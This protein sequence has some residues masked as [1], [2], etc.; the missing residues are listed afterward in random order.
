MNVNSSNNQHFSRRHFIGLFIVTIIAFSLFVPALFIQQTPTEEVPAIPAPVGD[1]F[2]TPEI[3]ATVAGEPNYTRESW[4]FILNNYPNFQ[5]QNPGQF[6]S[7]WTSNGGTNLG[8]IT[9]SP[10]GTNRGFDPSEPRAGVGTPAY[11]EVFDALEGLNESNIRIMY[12]NAD[13]EWVS[14]PYQIDPKGW[15]NVWQ[16]ADLNRW[17]GLDANNVY[18]NGG[19]PHIAADG[20]VG[21]GYIAGDMVTSQGKATY[22]GDDLRWDWYRIPVWTYL[23]PRQPDGSITDETLHIDPEYRDDLIW[24]YTYNTTY[25]PHIAW[26]EGDM[27]PTGA[28]GS[29]NPWNAQPLPSHSATRTNTPRYAM[30]SVHGW[31]PAFVNCTT[32]TD[33]RVDSTGYTNVVFMG[34]TWFRT[35]GDYAFNP[36]WVRNAF[37]YQQINGALDKDDEIV[38]YASPGRKAA[39]WYWWNYTYFPH[40]FEL[41]I[42][43]PIDGGRTW[44]YIYFNNESWADPF[45]GGINL[46]APVFTAPD[47]NGNPTSDYI[48]W[49]P[50]TRTLSSD[51]YQVSLNATNPSLID[52][53]SIF[54]DTDGQPIAKSFN[55]MYLYGRI[56]ETMQN[57]W[58]ALWSFGK[59]GVWYSYTNGAGSAFSEMI[60]S[61][62]N[63]SV[64][65]PGIS[66]D[67]GVTRTYTDHGMTGGQVTGDRRAYATQPACPQN[68]RGPQGMV[69]YPSDHPYTQ[70]ERSYGDGRA[71]IDGPVRIIFYTQQWLVTGLYVYLEVSGTIIINDY[72]D[73]MFPIMDGPS[74]YY[75]RAQIAPEAIVE[76]PALPGFQIQIYYAYI[77]CGEIN[78][79]IRSDVNFTT[80]VEWSGQPNGDTDSVTPTFGWDPGTYEGWTKLGGTSDLQATYATILGYNR[81]DGDDGAGDYYGSG[82]NPLAN[83]VPDGANQPCPPDGPNGGRIAIQGGSLPSTGVPDWAMATS[84]THG[85]IWLYI[86]RREVFEV[87]DNA[88]FDFNAAYGSG[89]LHGAGWYGQPKLYFRD[90]QYSAEFGVCLDGGLT[91]YVQ[92]GTKTSPY[93]MM[94][95]YDDFKHSDIDQGH[96]FYLYYFH[97]LEGESAFRADP[98]PAGQFLYDTVVPDKLIYKTGDTIRIDITGSPTNTVIDADFDDIDVSDPIYPM[99]NDT[100]GAWYIEYTIDSVDG[101]PS[102]YERNIQFTADCL[103]PM[104]TTDSVYDLSVT[105]DNVNPTGA[106]FVA[107]PGTTS[108]AFVLLDWSA[109][110][111]S[112]VGSASVSNPSGLSKYRIRRGTSPG[113]YTTVLAD[114]IPITTTQFLDSFVL[115]GGTYYYVIDTYDEVENMAT[116]SEVSTTISLPYTPAQPNDLPTTIKPSFTLDWTSNPGYGEGV[117]ITGY[118]VYQATSTDGSV[119]AAGAYSLAPGGS[120]GLAKTW[121]S[122]ASLIEARYYFYKVRTLTSGANL[123]SSP[124]STRIDTVAPLPAELATPLPTYNAEKEEIIVSWAIATLPQYQSGGFPGQDLNGIDH[125]VV[126]KKTASGS[127]TTLGSVP[128]SPLTSG[129]RIVD[130]AVSDGVQYSYAIRTFDGAGNSALC[131]AN[132]TT[133]LNVVGPGVAEPYSVVAPTTEVQQGQTELSVTVVVRNPGATSVTL[134]TVQLLFLKDTTNVTSDY[135]NVKQTPGVVLNAGQN[136]TYVFTVDVSP[137]ANTGTITITAQTVYDTTKTKVGAIIHDSWAVLPNATL[138]VQSVLSGF[139]TVHPGEQDIPVTVRVKNSG[140][141]NATLATL[142]LKFTRSGTDISNKFVVELISTL[143]TTPFTGNK[144]IQLNVSVSQSIT[145]GG[146]TVD[147]TITG[148]AAG[149]PLSDT[150]GAITPLTWAVTTWPKPVIASVVADKSVYWAPPQD[151][152][153]LTVTCDKAGH[154]VKGYFGNVQAGAGNQTGSPAGGVKYEI[155]FTLN[156]PVGEGTYNV[157]VYAEN[158]S[159][160]T[161]ATIGIRLGQAPTFS[162]QGQTPIDGQVKATDIV[163][164]DIDINDNGGANNVNAYLIYRTDGS[165][166]T[167]RTMTYA[168]SAH[169]DVTIPKQPGGSYVEYIINASDQVG[170]WA[171][172]SA[173]YTVNPPP[174]TPLLIEG[175]ESIHAAGDPGT[176]YNETPG[177]GAQIGSNTEYTVSIDTSFVETPAFYVVVVSAFDPIR[178]TFID[179]NS[180]VWMEAPINVEVT[181]SVFFDGN[182]ITTPRMIT[183]KIFILTDL[184]S[185][186]GRTVSV[187]SF[188]HY[189]E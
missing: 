54:G 65:Y 32:L 124:V 74:F 177:F 125:W 94:M 127:W 101:L 41:E 116:S 18:S 134:N 58:S 175:S 186:H 85:G 39:S 97:P 14:S 155:T 111:G 109:S 95:V 115:N 22:A 7:S 36:Q 188:V 73:L 78:K 151:T 57:S 71:V 80:A 25:Y 42:T 50:D 119:P 24:C 181:L 152:I 1:V 180:S 133:T 69:Q 131:L 122:P 169:W 37:P 148:S 120:V 121:T 6:D 156:T 5:W 161:T 147:A 130:I 17:G 89:T 64:V 12:L 179:V 33:P 144:D 166:W 162:N 9:Y 82:G 2:N 187:L 113:T 114:N 84:E 23:S 59:E 19:G 146:V 45:T 10:T 8:T 106:S 100:N 3:V 142:Q 149:V 98:A 138:N 153:K 31:K 174:T 83:Q 51:Y 105:I 112:D 128:Y 140:T 167:Q 168:G 189:L 103:L 11:E 145:A 157:I 173:S 164:I 159:G 26:L 30:L 137:T 40:R 13:Y 43:D 136:A 110:P 61:I 15:T 87:L 99:L 96:L 88:P 77:M 172:Y 34:D 55:R 165:S 143:P 132:K 52:S 21:L 62:E 150:D 4:P 53:V 47:R 67:T 158:A 184:P 29:V 163:D 126:Y 27:G 81:F 93:R 76:I 92:G 183:G 49:D 75:R 178:Q 16:V 35:P 20:T 176:Q 28:A 91:P 60:A 44:M 185:N 70:W 108:E 135:S 107:L 141:T 123:Y 38:F 79:D 86:P 117:T 72:V 102:D 154:T 66:R 139:L 48:S 104:Y 171:T 118:Q 129:Q 170:N 182:L 56:Q 90:D 160:T 46:G 68:Y 63:P